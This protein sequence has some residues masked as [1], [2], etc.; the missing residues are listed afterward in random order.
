MTDLP[1]SA[2]ELRLSR[3]L[4]APRMTVWRCWSEPELMKQWFT[5]RPWTTP[6]IETDF[7]PGGGSFILMR[8]PNGE[9]HENHGVYLEIDPGRR[10]VFTDA[11]RAGWLPSPKPFFTAILTFDDEGDGTRYTATARHWRL[12]DKTMHEE[13][14]F[15]D[16]WGKATDQLEALAQK[17]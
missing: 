1:S 16:G 11:Y 9:E 14:G 8:G 6:V 13:M 5:P 15:H 2:L 12:E 4:A 17:V 10:L 7:R 3:H